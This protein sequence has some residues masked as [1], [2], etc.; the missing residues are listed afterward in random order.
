MRICIRIPDSLLAEVN[1]RG[2]TSNSIRE[3]LN[4]YFELLKEA[5]ESIKG[6]FGREEL[7]AIVAKWPELP[8]HLLPQNSAKLLSGTQLIA[9]RDSLERYQIA[10][11]TGIPVDIAGILE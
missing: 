7:E 1:A 5:R 8:I 6:M 3:G 9:L 10:K 2:E 4:R 11:N